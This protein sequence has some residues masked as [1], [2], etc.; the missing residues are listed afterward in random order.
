MAIRTPTPL[1]LLV[2]FMVSLVALFVSFL[3]CLVVSVDLSTV[4]ISLLLIFRFLVT[5]GDY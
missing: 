1:R 5:V 4:L 2:F 3:S